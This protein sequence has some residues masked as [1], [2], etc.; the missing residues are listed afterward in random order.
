MSNIKRHSALALKLIAFSKEFFPQ[1]E[2]KTPD[3]HYDLLDIVN[4]GKDKQL[5]CCFR[6]SAKSTIFT[7][8]MPIYASF[9]GELEGIQTDFIMIVS[10][11]SGQAEDMIRE[12]KDLHDCCS[13]EFKSLLRPHNI[14][15]AD[16]VSFINADGHITSI[17]ARG[18][19]QKVRG[20]KRRGKRPSYLII[21]DLENDEAVLNEQNR[22]KLKDWFYKALLPCLS[23]TKSKVFYA[24][25]PLHADSLLENLRN[26]DLWARA[27]FPIENKDGVPLWEDR[28]TR[29]WI[30]NKKTEMKRQRMLTSF[31]QEYMLQIM[32][33]EDQIF[34][35]EY[36][37][38]I[39][40]ADL[41]EDLEIYITGDL[42]ISEAKTADRTAFV[43]IGISTSNMIYLL[44][45]VAERMPPNQQVSELIRLCNA[46]YND[47]KKEPVTLGIEMVSYQKS[48]KTMF[49]KELEKLTIPQRTKIPRIQELK[50]D[51]K[52]ERRIQQLEP[53]FYRKTILMVKNK[54]SHL[55]EEELLMF[56]RAKHDD[57]SD[58]FAYILQLIR[59]REG[60]NLELDYEEDYESY[61]VGGGAW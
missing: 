27:E 50:P 35:P 29:E 48:F 53:F 6:G 61:L 8:W 12:I 36:I 58:A 7:K 4:E 54:Y 46:Y 41:P 26:D 39:P 30:K 40:M 25:T 55:L 45:I 16:E 33:D 28:F 44:D 18:A 23:P 10:D 14:W 52:K 56:P 31:Y 24:G 3:F 57:I 32:S 2:N 38:Y 34:K 22:K 19:G 9:F 21:D 15:K 59:W 51:A 20:I 37:K 5:V 1:E 47:K 42:A 17:V 43:V 60:E 49:D 13:D 11:T